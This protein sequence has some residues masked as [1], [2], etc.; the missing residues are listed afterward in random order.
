MLFFDQPEEIIFRSISKILVEIG[1]KKN[2]A[3]GKKI[4]NLINDINSNTKFKKTSL[5]GC[6]LEK[7]NNSI[8]ISRET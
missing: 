6:I 5:S 7:I 2:Y 8:V 4:T 3:R 1:K